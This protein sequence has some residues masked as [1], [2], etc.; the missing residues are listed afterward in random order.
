MTSP[1]TSSKTDTDTP[2]KA[3]AKPKAADLAASGESTDPAVHFA[4]ANLQAALMNRK[5]LDVEEADI[6]AADA[7]VKAAQDA[8]AELGYK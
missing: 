3:D 8:L 4:M 5:A 1:T 7:E 2:T 6:K